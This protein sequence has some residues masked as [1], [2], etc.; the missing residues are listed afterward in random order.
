MIFQLEPGEKQLMQYEV[1]LVEERRTYPATLILTNE[2]AVL[3]YA[4]TP[5]PWVWVWMWMIALVMKAAAH[6]RERVRFQMR[7]ERFDSVEEGEGGI[8]VFH[9]IGEGYAHTSFAIASKDSFATWVDRMHRWRAGTTDAAAL[10][11]AKVVER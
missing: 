8:L 5:R 2:R 7:R 10:P 4:K 11:A 1:R 6:A 9:D 3:T